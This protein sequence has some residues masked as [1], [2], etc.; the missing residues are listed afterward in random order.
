MF[1]LTFFPGGLAT[2]SIPVS[3]MSLSSVSAR[4]A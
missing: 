2:I 1:W 4:L 3:S